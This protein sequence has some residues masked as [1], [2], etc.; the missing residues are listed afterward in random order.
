MGS[1]AARHLNGVHLHVGE[2]RLHLRQPRKEQ[3]SVRHRPTQC[4]VTPGPK[5]LPSTGSCNGAICSIMVWTVQA[6]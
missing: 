2:E 5:T 3:G 6:L 4:D 1:A